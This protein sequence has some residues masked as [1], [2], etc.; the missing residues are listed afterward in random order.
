[1]SI[2]FFFFFSFL[3]FTHHY[4]FLFFSA[5]LRWIESRCWTNDVSIYVFVS[6]ILQALMLL[7][8]KQIHGHVKNLVNTSPPTLT[9]VLECCHTISRTTASWIVIR[10]SYM[11]FFALSC[12]RAYDVSFYILLI[13]VTKSVIGRTN[14][15]T[16]I[17]LWI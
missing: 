10:W 11:L 1:M 15:S 14:V 8:S 3:L 7:V 5:R 13:H 6:F 9:H 4:F 2:I 12:E 16:V 17:I